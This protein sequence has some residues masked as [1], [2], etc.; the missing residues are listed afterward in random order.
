MTSTSN[1]PASLATRATSVRLD[2]R[3]DVS[4]ERASYLAIAGNGAHVRLSPEAFRLLDAAKSGVSPEVLARALNTHPNRR[5]VTA[6]QLREATLGMLAHLDRIAATPP[7][8]PGGF[9]ATRPLMPAGLVTRVAQR[10][11]WLY[12]W[13]AVAVAAG[14]VA[15]AL[16]GAP[17]GWFSLATA[18]TALAAGYGLFLVSLVVHEFGHAAACRRFGLTPGA[19]GFT[20]YLVFPALY[21]DVT[22][23]WALP[24]GQRVVV[25]LGGNYLQALVGAACL[26]LFGVTGSP[27]FGAGASLVALGMLFSLNPV[28]KCD[29]YWAVAD[30]LGVTNLSRQP[31][32]L[33]RG[34]ARR[35]LDGVPWTFPWPKPVAAALVLYT[36]LT[37]GVWVWFVARLAPMLTARF[38]GLDTQVAEVATAIQNQGPGLWPACLGLATSLFLLTAS[39]VM[40]VRMGQSLAPAFL[41]ARR[42]VV[43]R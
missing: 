14:I 35:L 13:P 30:A 23:A 41:K 43:D 37:V 28:F 6:E 34:F 39:V 7:R 15:W 10:L 2:R 24:R 19:V 3:L 20:M 32:V 9:W 27:A 1:R 36:G 38:T 40:V 17:P 12:T 4:D 5:P 29:G 11:A 42:T 8:A 26:W 22:R 21:T 33:V 25:D 18:D 16:A 31:R